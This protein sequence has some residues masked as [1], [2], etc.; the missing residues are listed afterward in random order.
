MNVG[1]VKKG[2]FYFLSTTAHIKNKKVYFSCGRNTVLQQVA[3][4]IVQKQK[5][6]DVQFRLLFHVFSLGRPMTNY[7]ASKVLFEQLNVPNFPLKH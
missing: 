5:R 7:G 4:G 2:N 1:K 3:Q 6:K